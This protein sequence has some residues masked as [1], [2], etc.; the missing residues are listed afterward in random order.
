MHYKAFPPTTTRIDAIEHLTHIDLWGKYPVQS[1]NRNQYYILMIDDK[2]RYTTIRFLKQKSQATQHVQNYITQLNVR[3]YN[4]YAI[5]VDR[6]TKFLNNALKTWCAKHGIE[7]Q[8]TAPNSPSQNGVAE[9]MNRT[10]VKL[11]CTMINV[12]NLPEFLWEPAVAHAAYVLNRSYM[13]ALTSTTPYEIMHRMWVNVMHFHKFKSPLWILNDGP[14]TLNRILPK[15]TQKIFMGFE[16]GAHMSNIIPRTRRGYSH[17]G[18]I[19]LLK[20][21]YY[22]LLMKPWTHPWINMIE[23][24]AWKQYPHLPT[25]C[26]PPAHISENCVWGKSELFEN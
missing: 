21:I 9:R 14:H 15:A 20:Q 19:N 16:D 6:G 17:P 1:I 5:R 18:I 4:T 8:T 23:D 25:T 11:A 2:S 3:G 22:L 26:L 7:I 24:Q 10:I 13:Q 12:Q